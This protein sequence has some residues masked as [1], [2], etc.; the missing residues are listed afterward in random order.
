MCLGPAA[1]CLLFAIAVV[2]QSSASEFRVLMEWRFDRPGDLQGWTPGGIKDLK[3]EGGTLRGTPA[4]HDPILMSPVFELPASPF[5][6]VRVTIR[7]QAVGEAEL[8]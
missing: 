4:G 7:C 1:R 6:G 3:V 5:H 2:P 8:F